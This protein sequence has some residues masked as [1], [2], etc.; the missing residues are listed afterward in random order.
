MSLLQYMDDTLPLPNDLAECQRLIV[1]LRA[2]LRDTKSPSAAFETASTIGLLHSSQQETHLTVQA[3]RPASEVMLSPASEATQRVANGLLSGRAPLPSPESQRLSESSQVSPDCELPPQSIQLE[4]LVAQVRDR[5]AQMRDRDARLSELAK[6]ILALQDARLGL[7]QENEKLRLTLDKLLKQIYGQRGERFVEDPAQKK[8]ALDFG[9]DPQAEDTFQDAIEEAQKVIREVESRRKAKKPVPQKRSERFPDHLPRV[10]KII[11][12]S[13]QQKTCTRHGERQFVAYDIVETLKI[14]RPEL[15]V[16]VTKYPKYVCAGKPDCGVLQPE[17]PRGLMSGNR[18]DTSI[19]VEVVSQKLFFHMPYYRQQDHYARLGWT[20]TRSTLQ[21]ILDAA[22]EVLYPLARHYHEVLLGGQI[23]GCDETRVTLIVP[24]VIP[25]INPEDP[26]SQRIHDVF[27]AAHKKG[28]PSV[29]ARMW[30]YRG[31]DVPLN[32]FD[33]TV[34]RHR[35]GPD[36]IL[37]KYPGTLLGDCWSGFH[38]IELRSELRITRAACWAHARRK[39]FD[40]RSS[41]PL[42]SATL[43]AVIQQLYDIE[44]RGKSLSASGCFL[45]RQHESIPLLN[46]IRTLIDSVE[47]QTVLPKSVFAEALRYLHNHWKALLVYTTNGLIPIDNNDVEQL[48]KQVAIGRRNWLF[49]GSVAAGNRAAT[50]LTLISS[51]V[52]HD[53]DVGAYLKDVLDQLLAGSTNYESMRADVWKQSHPEHIRTYRQEERQEASDRRV[54]KRAARRIDQL[55]KTAAAKANAKKATETEV[56]EAAPKSADDDAS[57]NQGQ[58][59]S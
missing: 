55:S 43:L 25:S 38:Q 39:V 5:D 32:L 47:Y 3:S 59:P 29:E 28:Q 22:A 26:R 24:P 41:H 34:S 48:M 14:K 40:G 16:E 37:K 53:L 44:D 17:R 18:F 51:A 15:Y 57:P 21:N 50:L 42:Q 33:F 49:L 31:V 8:L 30:A 1:E 7:Q 10:E 46:Q 45:L 56:P 23:L 52:R 27:S 13:E 12:V 35:D 6:A 20:P 54:L 19:A 36:E 4:D 58:A 9:N 2:K 11:D